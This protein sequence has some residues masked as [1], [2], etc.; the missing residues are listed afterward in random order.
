MVTG[1]HNGVDFAITTLGN[2]VNA[3]GKRQISEW[4]T[5]MHQQ[6]YKVVPFKLKAILPKK[7]LTISMNDS[8]RIQAAD[9]I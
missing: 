9:K 2:H 8:R 5:D 4:S 7:K 6:E 3:T 1:F